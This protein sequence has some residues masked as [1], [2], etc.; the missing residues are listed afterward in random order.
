MKTPVV[1]AAWRT[2]ATSGGS[3]WTLTANYYALR[4]MSLNG[5]PEDVAESLN[6][7]SNKDDSDVCF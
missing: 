5:A 3:K 7:L 1:V 6:Y 4:N 2:L